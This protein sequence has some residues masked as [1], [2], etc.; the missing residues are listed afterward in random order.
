[1]SLECIK[2]KLLFRSFGSYSNMSSP[3][4]KV[5]YNDFLLRKILDQCDFSTRANVSIAVET[6]N[7][8]TAQNSFDAVIGA[9][10]KQGEFYCPACIMSTQTGS[11]PYSHGVGDVEYA[12][13]NRV[14][15]V[16]Y[17]LYHYI[18]ETEIDTSQAYTN[19]DTVKI[20]ESKYLYD[21][22]TTK[23]PRFYRHFYQCLIPELRCGIKY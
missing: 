15:D 22:K 21:Y 3:G 6:S 23:R 16:K 2:I 20:I 10:S 13:I 5:F 9:K 8:Q 12:L 11:I 18:I 1:M 7:N 17:P 14:R 4:E 19:L